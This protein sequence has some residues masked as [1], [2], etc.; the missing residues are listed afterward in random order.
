MSCLPRNYLMT[1]G[2]TSPAEAAAMAARG[3]TMGR[4]ALALVIAGVFLATFGSDLAAIGSNIVSRAHAAKNIP[5]IA[6]PMYL[7]AYA[8]VITGRAGDAVRPLRH[9][10]AVDPTLADVQNA[11]ALAIFTATPGRHRLALSAEGGTNV[12]PIR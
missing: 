6:E 10:A 3:R 8:S 1:S 4:W 11:L 5:P 7:S 9:L 12:A 2:P